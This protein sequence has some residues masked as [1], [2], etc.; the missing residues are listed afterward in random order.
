MQYKLLAHAVVPKAY[1]CVSIEQKHKNKHNQLERINGIQR[2]PE[3]S[4]VVL[5]DA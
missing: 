5:D 3:I 2:L 4:G 1:R